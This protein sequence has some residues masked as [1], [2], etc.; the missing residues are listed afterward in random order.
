MIFF[1]IIVHIYCAE[2]YDH[3]LDERRNKI[4]IK[5]F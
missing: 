1:K 3:Y 4:A 5:V 2:K